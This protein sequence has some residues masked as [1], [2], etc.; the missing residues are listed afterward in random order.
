MIAGQTT[1]SL[2]GTNFVRADVIIFEATPSDGI[3]SGSPVNSSSVTIVDRLP[4]FGLATNNS[5]PKINEVTQISAN[6]TDDDIISMIIFSWN[7]TSTGAWINVSNTTGSSVGLNYSINVSVSLSRGNTIGYLFYSNDSIVNTFTASTLSTF[8]I[9]NTVPPA[10]SI[11][12]GSEINT[13]TNITLNITGVTDADS[14]TL[15][16]AIYFESTNPPRVL[17]ANYTTLNFTT[18]MT[19]DT[20]YFINVSVFDGVSVT[21]AT[22]ITNITLDTV[23]PVWQESFVT[24]GSFYR[25]STNLT[26]NC[27]DKNLFESNTSFARTGGAI[28]N[29]INFTNLTSQGGSYKINLSID[30]SAGDGVYNASRWCGDTKNRKKKMGEAQGWNV[31]KTDDNRSIQFNNSQTGL[32]CNI[33][34]GTT[35]P[36]EK[37]F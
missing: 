5:A 12:N 1:T 26:Y 21:P 10:T 20:I 34:Y 35:N 18:N 29:T 2:A 22:I 6:V 32:Q 27:T 31:A 36:A 24:N 16:Y 7:S 23:T 15:Y 25:I 8:V 30:I 37:K 19:N 17:V 33:S 9:T 28:I 4:S 11:S 14:D 3:G 13:N